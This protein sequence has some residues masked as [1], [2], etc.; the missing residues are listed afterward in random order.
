MNVEIVNEIAQEDLDYMVNTIKNCELA[1]FEKLGQGW[2]SNVYG[3]EKYAVK[4]LK[5]S[6]DFDNHECRDVK[7]LKDLSDLE[8][9]PTLYAVIDNRIMITERVFGVTVS[10]VYECNEKAVDVDLN[11][12]F[13]DKFEEYLIDVIVGGYSPQD[14]HGENVMIDL[15]TNKPKFVDTGW[16]RR[17]NREF[18]LIDFIEMDSIK[19]DVGYYRAMNSCGARIRTILA[20]KEL[21]G[22]Y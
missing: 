6:Y 7:V 1:N 12:S 15:N 21:Q 13:L 2:Y 17:N 14:L 18:D 19:S 3:Y 22:V 5:D 20:N 11:H 16:F 10:D 9:V 4:I 8:C